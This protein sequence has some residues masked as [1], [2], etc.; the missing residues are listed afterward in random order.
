MCISAASECVHFIV[1]VCIFSHF[2]S[3]YILRDRNK[4]RI[5]WETEEKK[6]ME[7][8][9]EKRIREEDIIICNYVLVWKEMG[10]CVCFG[11]FL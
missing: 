6:I 7:T 5:I 1:T 2:F 11:H 10:A 3:L 9:Q 4:D 8:R